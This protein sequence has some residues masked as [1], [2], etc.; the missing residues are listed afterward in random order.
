LRAGDGGTAVHGAFG[1]DGVFRFLAHINAVDP[2]SDLLGA[3][4]DPLTSAGLEASFV[5]VE[6]VPK[7]GLN[8][9]LGKDGVESRDPKE[10]LVD[11]DE[12]RVTAG[13]RAES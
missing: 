8:L 12:T 9:G 10:V 3:V 2:L 6:D 7:A 4:R 5:S 11:M 13:F 1:S